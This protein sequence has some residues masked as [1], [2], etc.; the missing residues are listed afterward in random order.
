MTK[1]KAE[2]VFF[3]INLPNFVCEISEIKVRPCRN[4]K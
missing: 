3:L 1:T 4:T 2:N